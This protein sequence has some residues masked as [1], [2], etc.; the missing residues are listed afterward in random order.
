MNSVATRYAKFLLQLAVDQQALANVS[1]DMQLIEQAHSA[2][3]S[4]RHILHSSTIQRPKKN[5]ILQALFQ[6]KVHTITLQFLA[7]IIQKRREQ[8]LSAIA[9]AFLVQ[10]D[11]RQGIQKACVTTPVPLSNTLAQQ[12]QQLVQ[13]VIPCQRVVLEQRL[14]E[15][16]IGGFVLQ[17]ADHRLDQSLRKQL[18]TLKKHW[19]APGY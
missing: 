13:K 10:Y 8:L 6:G 17:T 7:L 2:H 15:T 5:A 18:Q 1:A 14:D 12:I 3:P 11:Q 16:L 9:Q 19:V 4:L